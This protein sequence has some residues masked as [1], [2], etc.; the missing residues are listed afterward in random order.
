M[1]YN[2]PLLKKKSH[3]KVGLD[4][5]S[6]NLKVAEI[7]IKESSYEIVGLG[8]KDI[9]ETKNISEAIK[10]M[11]EEARISTRKV[12]TSLSGENVVARY[13][14]LPKMTDDE[15]KKAV[16]YELED[17]IPFKADEVYTNYYILG[18]EPNSKNRMK[19]FLVA[20]KKEPLDNMVKVIREAKLEPEVVTMDAL[21][22]KNTFYFNYP[23]KDQTNIALLNIGDK[24]TNI[25]ITREQIPY[26]VRDTR[27]GGNVITALIQQ[28]NSELDKKGA[29]EF[30]YNLQGVSPD[31]LQ[32]IKR[33]LTNLLNEIFIS[34]D[35][36]ENL[37]ERRI[38]EVYISGGSSKLFGLNEFLS[39]YLG[40]EIITLNPFKNFSISPNVPQ[41]TILKLSPY[42]AVAI[43]LALEEP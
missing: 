26:F 12:N 8:M 15:L 32:I 37:T 27:F 9:R 38:D 35:F 28:I 31:I 41:E 34:L 5:G 24:I 29:E 1:R 20:T 14:S 7:E 21:A 3:R 30:K 23:S 4:I 16:V 10:E 18:D 22:I 39:G 19:V 6:Y 13:L 33:T 2:L 11:F 36:Y 40:I 25:L 42:F 17:H 43:G